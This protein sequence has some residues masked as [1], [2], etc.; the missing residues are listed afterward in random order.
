MTLDYLAELLTAYWFAPPVGL[1]RAVELRVAA[2]EQYERP[3]LDLGCGDGLVGQV[4]FGKEPYADV[5]LDPWADQV[6]RAA[7][8]GVYRHLAV[9]DG[10]HL[11][12]AD[13]TFATVFSNSVLEHIPDV[14]KI[15][16]EVGRVL[17]CPDPN[18]GQAGGRFVFTVPSDAFRPFLDGYVR[19]M[20]AGHVRGAE[21]YAA[22]VDARLEHYHY[23]TPREW[24]RLL[25]SAGMTLVKARYYIPQEVEQFWD[26]MNVSYG[27]GQRRS[28]WAMLVSPRL[29]ALGYQALVRRI[30]VRILGRYWR[31]Y[32]EMDVPL[33]EKGGG[34]LI[35]ARRED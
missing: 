23:H 1:W 20:A 8:T 29:R 13:G 19:K 27:I 33:G 7:R 3:L 14:G 12:Y 31:R 25:A 35:V 17:R 28:A 21:A 5:G 30:V 18:T 4:L 2:E 32:Y 26:R 9:G 10:H 11:P 15:V 6:R 24:Q 16:H 22:A 34:L